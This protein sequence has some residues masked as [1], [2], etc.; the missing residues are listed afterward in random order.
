MP[1][2]NRRSYDVR[3]MLAMVVYVVV[4]LSVWPTVRSTSEPLVKQGLSE[5]DLSNF[6]YP[7]VDPVRVGGRGVLAGEA[8]GRAHADLEPNAHS[9]VGGA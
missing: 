9:A 6:G 2:D 5:R 7:T 4:F 8:S 3:I 1:R